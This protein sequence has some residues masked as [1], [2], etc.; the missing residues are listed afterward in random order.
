[1]GW[2]LWTAHHGP[3]EAERCVFIGSWPVCRR[4]LA[5]WPLAA[6]I[7]VATW[8]GRLPAPPAWE[9]AAWLAPAAV[10]FVGAALGRWPHRPGRTWA[11]GLLLGTGWG[12]LAALAWTPG[13]AIPAWTTLALF[14]AV[15]VPAAV[16]Q[17]IVKKS[18]VS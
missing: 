11:A 16:Y 1:M 13:G 8:T 10:E 9:P 15:T 3:E 2:P 18:T 6:A 7:L 12:R 17:A 14:A 4:C 5:A